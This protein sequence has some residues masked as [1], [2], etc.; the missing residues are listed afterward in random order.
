LS[1]GQGITQ[2]ADSELLKLFIRK[3]FINCS[4]NN[5]LKL[6]LG[7]LSGVNWSHDMC[8]MSRGVILRHHGF[9]GC[10]WSLCCG[11]ILD[12]F[13]KCLFKL[14]NGQIYINRI[15]YQLL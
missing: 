10:D 3:I 2:W 15:I 9:D 7:N 4:F 8:G 11:I 6:S 13:I 14:L 5:L 1:R 12:F